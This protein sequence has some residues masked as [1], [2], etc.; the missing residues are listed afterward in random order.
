M[1]ALA[2]ELRHVYYRYPRVDTWVLDDINLEVH[3]NSL[4][5]LVG[6]TGSGKSTLLKVTRGLHGEYGGEFLGSISVCGN[7]ISGSRA[8]ELGSKMAIV[9]QNPACQLHQPRVIDEI[10]SAP[11]YQGLPFEECLERAQQSADEILGGSLLE[12]NPADLSTGEQQKVVLAASLSMKADVVLLDEPF[13]YLDGG[14]TDDLMKIIR[15]LKTQGKTVL[16]ATHDL[17]P[18]ACFADQIALFDEGKL[19]MQGAAK[20]VLYSRELAA[21][22]GRPLVVELGDRLFAGGQLKQR[23]TCWSELVESLGLASRRPARRA[24]SRQTWT[25]AKQPVVEVRRVSYTYANG[26]QAVR[27][28]SLAV[29][30][31]EI[32]GIVGRNGSGKTTLARLMIGLLK[33]GSGQV[34]VLGEDSRRLRDIAPRIGYVTQN[35]GDMLFETTVLRECSFGPISLGNRDAKAKAEAVLS[36][37][38][39]LKYAEKDP[40]SLSAGEQRLLTIADVLVNAPELLILDEPEFGLDP[41]SFRSIAVLIRALRDEGKS[42]V[43]IT[44]N[45]EATVFLCNRIVLMEGGRILKTASPS[46]IYCDRE[47]VDAAGLRYLPFFAVLESVVSETEETTM[48][49][50]VFVE[51]LVSQLSRSARSV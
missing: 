9:F 28:V 17:E 42:I 20:E 6:P 37:L 40:R 1:T 12:R 36:D 2:L 15:R 18:V 41:L 21:T 51:T 39:L 32:V 26:R 24:S 13:S 25:S 10:M 3:S 7:D 34:I 35:P 5:V 11:M 19:I 50:E 16:L 46:E 47:L 27:E 44:H 49:E 23:P 29:Q 48:T 31:G 43:M 8:S 30:R 33:P 22:V 14:A 45:L 38:G 4:L